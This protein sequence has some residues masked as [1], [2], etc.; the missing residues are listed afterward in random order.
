[1]ERDISDVILDWVK[2]HDPVEFF[3]FFDAVTG[4]S[5]PEDIDSEVV[6]R[7]ITELL[8]AGYRVRRAELDFI[9]EYAKTCRSD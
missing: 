8:D 6:D 9:H 7:F 4:V 2:S 3:E 1:M 5:G